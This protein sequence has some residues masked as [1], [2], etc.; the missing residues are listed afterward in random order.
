MSLCCHSFHYSVLQCV[1]ICT[2]GNNRSDV[3]DGTDGKTIG[4]AVG[5]PVP[6]GIVLI[7]AVAIV[8]VSC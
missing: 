6:I 4:L 2:I 7:V 3:D 1:F 8:I 5:I